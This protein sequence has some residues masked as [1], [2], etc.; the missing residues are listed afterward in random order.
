MSVYEKVKAEITRRALEMEQELETRRRTFDMVFAKIVPRL[1]NYFNKECD[2]LIRDGGRAGVSSVLESPVRSI[3]TLTFALPYEGL[4]T[5][6][7]Y[8]FRVIVAADR[9]CIAEGGLSEKRVNSP[10]DSKSSLVDD[11]GSID[12]P[13]FLIKLDKSFAKMLETIMRPDLRQ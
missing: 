9:L 4:E 13:D 10:S 7:S 2:S 12:A 3:T 1:E 11:L 6:P 5:G 8:I